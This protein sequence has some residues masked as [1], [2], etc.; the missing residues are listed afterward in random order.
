MLRN[1]LWIIASP[2]IL[3]CLSIALMVTIVGFMLVCVWWVMETSIR[4]LF[5]EFKSAMER[6]DW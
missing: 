4:W 6:C 1:L 5:H 2:V 3:T